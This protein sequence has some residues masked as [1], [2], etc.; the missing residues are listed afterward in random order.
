MNNQYV[1]SSCLPRHRYCGILVANHMSDF[2]L[3]SHTRCTLNHQFPVDTVYPELGSSS[4]VDSFK[5]W[6]S[7]KILNGTST[8]IGYTVPFTLVYGQ[9]T[10]QEQTLQKLNATQEKQTTQKHSKTKQPWFSCLLWHS[11][12]KRGGLIRQISRAT[13][14]PEPEPTCSFKDTEW[15]VFLWRV[16]K[17]SAMNCMYFSCEC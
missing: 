16:L 13:R 14:Q 10:N 6:V 1:L 5:D 9:Q 12:R 7:E 11:A 4:S 3:H 15:I 17:Q 2:Q 8:Q